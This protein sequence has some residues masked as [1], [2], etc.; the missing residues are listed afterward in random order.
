[1]HLQ[2]LKDGED[3]EAQD[4]GSDQEDGGDDAD[5]LYERV[6]A[7]LT[8]A[9]GEPADVSRRLTVS[10][11]VLCKLLPLPC[12]AQPARLTSSLTIATPPF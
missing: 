3:L 1:M 12:A 6:L 10:C 11:C 9:N 7:D 2:T 8:E 4:P 5:T